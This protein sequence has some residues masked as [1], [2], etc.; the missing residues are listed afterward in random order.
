MDPTT[1]P[2]RSRARHLKRAGLVLA[3]LSLGIAI[4]PAGQSSAAETATSKRAEVRIVTK[5]V[6]GPTITRTVPGPTVEKTPASCLAALDAAERGFDLAADALAITAEIPP[7]VADAARAGMNLDVDAIER[8]TAK[9]EKIN[10]RFGPVIDK[11][12]STATQF[13][14]AKAACRSSR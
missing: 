4:A 13:N 1:T 2:P 3:G 6:P 14:A 10:A 7:L 11:T 8:I 9:G 5:T 12:K